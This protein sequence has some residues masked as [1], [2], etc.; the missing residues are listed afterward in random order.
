MFM[1]RNRGYRKI[2]FPGNERMIGNLIDIKIES[3]TVGTLI[4][5]A[6]ILNVENPN[7]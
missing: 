1:G 6:D 5:S 2:I 3:A 7:L 4:G